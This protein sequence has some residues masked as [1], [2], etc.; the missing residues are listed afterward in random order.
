MQNHQQALREDLQQR[1]PNPTDNMTMG[2]KETILEAIQH[3]VLTR[4]QALLKYSLSPEELESWE[5]GYK[6]YGRA[7][8]G[9]KKLRALRR[10]AR[11][12]STT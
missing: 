7:G 6:T 4:T 11:Q 12:L 3:N 8:L 1:L 5:R 10:Q 2:R 9:L